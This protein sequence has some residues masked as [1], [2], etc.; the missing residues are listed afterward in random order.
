MFVKK[1]YRIAHKFIVFILFKLINFILIKSDFLI[2]PAINKV[3][4]SNFI[5]SNNTRR[6]VFLKNNNSFNKISI[7]GSTVVAI[8]NMNELMYAD[9]NIYSANPNFTKVSLNPGMGNFVNVSLQNKTIIAVDIEGDIWYT[10]NYKV[11]NWI[12]INNKI[13]TVM[14]VQYITKP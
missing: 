2:I 11:P 7:D 3:N 14:A 5:Y 9:K 8:N 13:K 12:K 1:I 6:L 10:S 4:F